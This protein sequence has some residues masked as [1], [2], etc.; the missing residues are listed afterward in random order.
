MLLHEYSHL[1]LGRNPIHNE[2]HLM[3][4][5]NQHSRMQDLLEQG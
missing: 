1:D 2:H 5:R 4:A 3:A